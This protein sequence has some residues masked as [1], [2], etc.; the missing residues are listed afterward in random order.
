[1]ERDMKVKDQLRMRRQ[2]LGISVSELAKRLDVSAQAVRYWESGRSFPGKAKTA[3]LESALSFNIDWTEGARAASK[4][5]SASALID[6]NDV[7]LLLQ[8]ARLPPPAKAL[9]ADLVRM[10]LEALGQEPGASLP[11]I[12]E[13]SARPFL[14]QESKPSAGDAA[15]VKQA[16][17]ASEGIRR[18]VGSNQRRQAR[19]KAA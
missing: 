14:E 13:S 19:R 15:R 18:A 2:Q 8:I 6:P 5:I 9:V 11:R 1:M 17:P 4:R 16:K 12:V 3:A 7:G 10:H